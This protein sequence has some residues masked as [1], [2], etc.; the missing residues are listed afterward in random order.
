MSTGSYIGRRVQRGIADL[1]NV[2]YDGGVSWMLMPNEKGI[3]HLAV[4]S[5]MLP[6]ERTE[7]NNITLNLWTK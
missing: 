4:M 2:H 6:P 5:H 1:K 7:V 3:V